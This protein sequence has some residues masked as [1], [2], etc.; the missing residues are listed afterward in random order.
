MQ[1]NQC[2]TLRAQPVHPRSPAPSSRPELAA[3]SAVLLRLRLRL[4]PRTLVLH[5]RHR[6]RR[7]ARH[8]QPR[9]IAACTTTDQ[10]VRSQRGHK[11]SRLSLP[12]SPKAVSM[13]AILASPQQAG[14]YDAIRTAAPAAFQR[15]LGD[16]PPE[17]RYQPTAAT[18]QTTAATAANTLGSA[19]G[20]GVGR[21]QKRLRAGTHWIRLRCSSQAPACATNQRGVVS[22]GLS[23]NR[24]NQ[25][26]RI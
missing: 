16:L 7:I 13:N 21:R 20:F 1:P 14:V 9:R 8:F 5:C 22:W 12:S 24:R 17:R 6:H 3:L 10:D 15:L 2:R 23:H 25:T 18:P 4:R 11:P 19:P 26:R